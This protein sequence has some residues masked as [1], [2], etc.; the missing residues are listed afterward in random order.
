[1]PQV[2]GLWGFRTAA[3]RHIPDRHCRLP[4]WASPHDTDRSQKNRRP[5]SEAE[6]R[7]KPRCAPAS[8]PRQARLCTRPPIRTTAP[9]RPHARRTCSPYRGARRLLTLRRG[10]QERRGGNAHTKRW[11]GCTAS[12]MAAGRKTSREVSRARTGSAVA[13]L[14]VAPSPGP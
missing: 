3:L 14:R 1:M 7:R 5:A 10:V 8:R 6:N 2:T 11:A 9:A 12:G 4:S 13:C